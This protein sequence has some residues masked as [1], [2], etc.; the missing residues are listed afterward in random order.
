MPN[1]TSA[2][3]SIYID[4]LLNNRTL[5][6]VSANTG[7]G[8]GNIVNRIQ[9]TGAFIP[10][11]A[12]HQ[13]I[14][15]QAAAS[16]MTAAQVAAANNTTEADVNALILG[17]GLQP[18][19]GKKPGG[20]IQNPTPTSAGPS[21]YGMGSGPSNILG[22]IPQIPSLRMVRKTARKQQDPNWKGQTDTILTSGRGVTDA[23]NTSVKTLLGS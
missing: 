7:I 22:S 1:L 11:V 18:L 21:S 19:G 8:T 2:E 14:Y 3:R 10:L 20:N 17:A 9:E 15:N 5:L 6:D 16:G 4:A 12:P 13:Q 23:A